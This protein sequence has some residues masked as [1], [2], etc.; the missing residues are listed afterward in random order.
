MTLLKKSTAINTSPVSVPS[1]AESV[2]AASL[3]TLAGVS[4]V[5]SV[6]QSISGLAARAR[7]GLT[8]AKALR[9]IFLLVYVTL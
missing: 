7:P 9:L 2:H 5:T 3:P 4:C 1:N 8:N 6:I